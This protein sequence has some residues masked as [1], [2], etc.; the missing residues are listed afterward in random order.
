MTQLDSNEIR[1]YLELF[2]S[3]VG[4]RIVSGSFGQPLYKEK[5]T[6]T[7]QKTIPALDTH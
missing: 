1:P 3:F 4:Q 5:P 6:V 2:I 7:W